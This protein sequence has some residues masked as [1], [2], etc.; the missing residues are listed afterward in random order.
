MRFQKT[1]K[2]GRAG[3]TLRR[4]GERLQQGSRKDVGFTASN[5][6]VMS[7]GRFVAIWKK[8]PASIKSSRIVPG[9]RSGD[10]LSEDVFSRIEVEYNQTV[11]RKSDPPRRKFY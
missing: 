6:E 8:N 2:L 9:K 1:F 3:A 5:R 11:L 4:A 7:V 10:A